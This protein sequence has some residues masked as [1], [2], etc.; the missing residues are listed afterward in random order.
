MS[1]RVHGRISIAWDGYEDISSAKVIGFAM[2]Q[3]KIHHVVIKVN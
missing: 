3:I 1:N 2:A